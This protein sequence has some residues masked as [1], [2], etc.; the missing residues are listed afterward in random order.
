MD[1]LG[2][3][4]WFDSCSSCSRYCL[5]SPLPPPASG[6]GDVFGGYLKFMHRAYVSL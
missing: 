1:E 5:L 3:F 6:R 4:T 2:S